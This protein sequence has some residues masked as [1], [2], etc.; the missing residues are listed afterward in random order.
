MCS[1]NT[2]SSLS[3]KT[4]VQMFVISFREWSLLTFHKNSCH[5]NFIKYIL[6]SIPYVPLHSTSPSRRR[7]VVVTWMDMNQSYGDC[8]VD[9]LV[10]HSDRSQAV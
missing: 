5:E 10:C 4:S 2:L 6:E 7:A 8:E 1:F 9:T 3:T